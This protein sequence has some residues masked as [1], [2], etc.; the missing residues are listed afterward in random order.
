M[1]IW[2]FGGSTTDYPWPTWADIVIDH[3]K[4][5]GYQGENW[6]I[7]GASNPLI[8]TK[9]MECHAKNNLGP[10]DHVFICFTPFFRDAW[11]TEEKGWHCPGRLKDNTVAHHRIKDLKFIISPE[12]YVMRDCAAIASTIMSLRHLGV[13]LYFWYDHELYKAD[14]D[15]LKIKKFNFDQVLEKYKNLIAPTHISL[16]GII[17]R[18]YKF[19][20]IWDGVPP[21]PEVHPTPKEY[22]EY[23]QNNL[24]PR[25]DWMKGGVCQQTLDFVDHWE[26]KI[27]SSDTVRL[28]DL[29][30]KKD[31][32]SQWR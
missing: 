17:Y 13:N 8:Q 22:L 31:T 5:L 14:S 29:G 18:K 3:A 27:R 32:A 1:R 21:Q 11:H 26:S 2:T 4:H 20:C 7:C 9:V 24:V 30:W 19:D 6:G 16:Q 10:N 28:S 15:L 12:H 25:V 23:I